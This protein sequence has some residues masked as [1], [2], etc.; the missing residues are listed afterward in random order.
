MSKPIEAIMQKD[1]TRKEFLA[2]LGFGMAAVLGFS[3]IIRLLTGK[4]FE[5]HLNK[6]VNLGYGSSPY[7]GNKE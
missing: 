5:G 6:T 7:G 4:S 2:T 1:M 3:N